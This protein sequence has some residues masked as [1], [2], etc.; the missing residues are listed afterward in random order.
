LKN[1]CKSYKEK[2]TAQKKGEKKR[3]QP[4]G[5]TR[6]RTGPAAKPA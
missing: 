6:S 5:L 3:Q 4:T 1:L 2:E